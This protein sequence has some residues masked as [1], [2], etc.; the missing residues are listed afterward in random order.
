MVELAHKLGRTNDGL[1]P[2]RKMRHDFKTLLTFVSIFCKH[3]HDAEPKTRLSLKTHDIDALAGRAVHLC[4]QC[5]RLATHALIK[6]TNCPMAPK[7]SCKS[8]PV[9]C[10]HATFREEMKE[11]MRFSGRKLLF[12]GRLDYLLH[13]LF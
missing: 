6:R 4:P 10:Y 12:S 11:V 2:D 1:K 3:Q 7:P 9:H 8:C 5:S 13:L